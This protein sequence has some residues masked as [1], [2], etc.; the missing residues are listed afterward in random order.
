MHI[1]LITGTEPQAGQQQL[2]LA[3]NAYGQRWQDMARSSPGSPSVTPEATPPQPRGSASRLQFIKLEVP[4]ESDRLW[5][6][7][8][9]SDQDPDHKPRFMILVADVGLGDVVAP[10]TT[11]ADLAWD[12]RIP[13]VVVVPVRPGAVGQAIAH[14]ALARQSRCHVKGLVFGCA[15]DA[16]WE[17][18][19]TLA[20]RLTVQRLTQTP[21]LGYLPPPHPHT[22]A[23][24]L[25]AIAADLDLERL[26]PL[27][28]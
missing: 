28:N 16:A 26:W 18:R 27:F 11:V 12:W 15:T 25:A 4:V 6:Q 1:L 7:L 3:L 24:Q 5:Q 21:V 22:T 23:E 9:T 17:Q 14:V 19:E 20:D 10:E 2:T 13:A 8:H